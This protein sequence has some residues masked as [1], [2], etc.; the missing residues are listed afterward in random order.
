MAKELS[1]FRSTDNCSTTIDNRQNERAKRKLLSG[2]LNTKKGEE[3]RKSNLVSKNDFS[4]F[5]QTPKRPRFSSFFAA[6]KKLVLKTF[7]FLSNQKETDDAILCFFEVPGR[8]L[9][10]TEIKVQR[11]RRRRQYPDIFFLQKKS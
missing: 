11:S 4:R 3:T 2:R 6:A 7:K 8:Q 9:F 5:F 1:T 10:I